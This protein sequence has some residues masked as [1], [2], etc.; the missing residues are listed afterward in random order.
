[1]QRFKKILAVLNGG[2]GSAEVERRAVAL[3]RANRAQLAFCTPK[4][5]YP[6][7]IPKFGSFHRELERLLETQRASILDQA[8]ESAARSGV[9]AHGR[10][11]QGK[12]F[13]SV[14]REVLRD[15]HD[16]VLYPDD[17]P[18]SIQ[19]TLFGSTAT[20][21]LR[22]C[23]CPVWVIKPPGND[24]GD[25]SVRRIVA[26]VNA[27]TENP[28]E[29]KLNRKILEL[30]TSLAE[31]EAA[32]AHVVHCW[33]VYGE[34]LLASRGRMTPDELHDY[35]TQTRRFHEE[36]LDGVLHRFVHEGRVI[37]PH[38]RKGDPGWEIPDLAAGLPADLVVMGTVA[39]TGVNGVFIGNTAESVLQ[40]IRCS[41][42]AV[43]PDGFASPV[44]L[45][46]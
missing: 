44:T 8:V 35:R 45:D 18:T 13:V 28:T 31:R 42:L 11:L 40:R 34:S 41:V 27:V 6:A 14:I 21:L 43:K 19:N 29:Q 39:R 23:P 30:T 16:I 17:E 10:D 5:G 2:P 22:K 36:A 37:E 3:A 12:A 15:G 26:A 38:L 33:S 24:D 1:M 46:D 9:E 7:A 4:V 20:H 25:R 32:E